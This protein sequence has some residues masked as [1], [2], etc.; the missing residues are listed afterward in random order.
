MQD[1]NITKKGISLT[2]NRN[3]MSVLKD[4]SNETRRLQESTLNDPF[5]LD[6]QSTLVSFVSS[7]IKLIYTD[8]VAVNF[9]TT[10]SAVVYGWSHLNENGDSIINTPATYSGKFGKKERESI[11]EVDVNNSYSKG[12]NFKYLDIVYE[13]IKDNPFGEVKDKSDVEKA[14]AEGFFLGTIRYASE[15]S[16]DDSGYKPADSSIKLQSW[17]GLVRTR[18]AK[19]DSTVEL[20]Q[21][22]ERT[23]YGDAKQRLIDSV[24]RILADEMNKDIIHKLITVS[25]RYIPDGA[26]SPVIDL[27]DDKRDQFIIGRDVY[28]TLSRMGGVIN[29]KT[30]FEPSYIVCSPSVKSYLEISGFV[31]QKTNL[32]ESSKASLILQNGLLVFEDTSAIF[33]YAVVGVNSE[34]ASSLYLSNFAIPTKDVDNNT[35]LIGTHQIHET[36]NPDDMSSSFMGISRYALTTCPYIMSEEDEKENRNV[37]MGDN[38]NELANKS[39]MSLFVGFR[40]PPIK[41]K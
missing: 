10:K 4:I 6:T 28:S 39:E 25:K 7:V 15:A 27:L 20:L 32:P 19:I 31:D 18:R 17:K 38:W 33:D 21:D 26:D 35:Q 41:F 36:I 13:V 3:L 9:T 5:I 8:L 24:A 12:D 2:E 16:D 34:N 11:D 23:L 1:K 40:L 14:L 30:K 22:M 29:A 37:I